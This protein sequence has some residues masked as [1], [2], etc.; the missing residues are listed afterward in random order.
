MRLDP[1]AVLIFDPNCEKKKDSDGIV[2]TLKIHNSA[3]IG[4]GINLAYKIKTT[5]P[6]S[7]QV[8]P[9]QGIVEPSNASVIEIDYVIL[10]VRAL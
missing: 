5:A 8:K 3:E 9:F 1:P 6:K 2:T 7:Y 4:N 10:P